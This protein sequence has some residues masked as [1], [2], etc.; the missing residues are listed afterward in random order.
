V[1]LAKQPFAWRTW[2]GAEV[3]ATVGNAEKKQPLVKEYG[4][5]ADHVFYSRNTSSGDAVRRATNGQGV[6][7]ILN[8]ITGDGLRESW[9]CLSKFGRFIEIGRREQGSKTRLEMNNVDSNASF[10]SVDLLALVAERPKVVKRLVADVA[11]LLKYGK[12]RP[13]THYCFLHLE[14]RDCVEDSTNGQGSWQTGGY[15]E[16]G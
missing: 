4:L 10:I 16:G 8:S 1:L 7:V 9:T 6:D 12:I 11:Q 2:S 3:F 5:P 14:H 15:A 13:V